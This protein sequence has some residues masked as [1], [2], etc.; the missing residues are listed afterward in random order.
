MR[1]REKV[2]PRREHQ[3]TRQ[4]RSSMCRDKSGKSPVTR[5]LRVHTS[6]VKQV[7]LLFIVETILR[8]PRRSISFFSAMHSLPPS[9]RIACAYIRMQVMVSSLRATAD[10]RRGNQFSSCCHSHFSNYFYFVMK[11]ARC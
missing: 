9:I 4:I 8:E 3:E 6:L 1:E 10:R 2:W 7:R 5:F 11:L